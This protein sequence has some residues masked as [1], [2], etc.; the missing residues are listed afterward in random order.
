MMAA[1]VNFQAPDGG[2]G[3]F[4]TIDFIIDGGLG[5]SICLCNIDN[6][7]ID[8][9]VAGL[10]N[11]IEGVIQGLGFVEEFKVGTTAAEKLQNQ[12]FNPKKPCTWKITKI[13]SRFHTSYKLDEYSLIVVGSALE[14][15]VVGLRQYF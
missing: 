4:K 2:W 15:S 13:S 9:M 12:N 3:S 8:S 1:P 5:F 10:V 7:L 14:K 6:L 11:H